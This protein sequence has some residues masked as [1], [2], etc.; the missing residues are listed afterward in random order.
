M[1]PVSVPVLSVQKTS[2]LP[3][4]SIASRRRTRTPR[5]AIVRAPRASVTLTIAGSNSGDRPTASAMANSSDSMARPAQDLIHGQ[6]EQHHDDHHADEQVAEIAYAPGELG[7]RRT[8]GEMFGDGPEDRLPAGPRDQHR[9][10]AAAHRR[11]QKHAVRA[12][13]ERRIGGPRARLLR[14]RKRLAGKARLADQEIA[15]VEDA[16]SAGT[17]LPAARTTTSPGTRSRAADRARTPSRQARAVSARRSRSS[18]IAVDARYSC[19][20]P[21]NALPITMTRMMA[22]SIQSR[23]KRGSPHRRPGS[24]PAGLRTGARGGPDDRSC[25]LLHHGVGA[26]ALQAF[27]SLARREPSGA[28]AE[29]AEQV[30]GLPA[31]VVRERVGVAHPAPASDAV[32]RGAGTAA[33]QPKRC[34]IASRSECAAS[35]SPCTTHVARGARWNPPSQ[36]SSP[37]RSACAERPPM[38]WSVPVPGFV[39]ED[40]HRC[41]RRRRGGARGFPPPGNR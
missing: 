41:A 23:R 39:V 9:G 36:S 6:H 34:S 29:G 30:R 7:F 15:C 10:R 37:S 24:A 19:R 16:P 31:P 21:S 38:V 13:G 22:A 26:D 8:R 33:R 11:S 32:W 40:A 1:P 28:R 27:S 12:R 14:H 3:R 20:K 25:A 2:M 4:F 35:G 5:C 17:R 18:A